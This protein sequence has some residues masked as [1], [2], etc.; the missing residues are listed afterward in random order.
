MEI[1]NLKTTTELYTSPDQF[2]ETDGLRLNLKRKHEYNHRSV[3]IKTQKLIKGPEAQGEE[4]SV[5]AVRDAEQEEEGQVNTRQQQSLIEIKQSKKMTKPQWH[6][7][8]KLKSVLSGHTG[9]VRAIAV[10]P[11]NEWF[12]SGAGDRIIKVWDLASGVLKVSLTGHVATVRGLAISDRHPY[13]FSAGEDKQIKCWDL[14]YNK[15]IRHYHGHLS[16]IYSLKLH[17]TLDLLVS[18]GR[19]STAR[20]QEN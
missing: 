12:A 13:M 14:E 5:V 9:W 4:N 7:P 20:V 16:G 2:I 19:D 15:V 8:W 18:G 6:A 11:S 10:D 3:E 17:P 1:I